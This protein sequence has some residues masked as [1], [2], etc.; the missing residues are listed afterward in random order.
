MLDGNELRALIRDVI[1]AEIAA[2]K[3]EAA[4]AKAM[5]AEHRVRI[6][7]DADLAA[8][9]KQVLSLANDP[10]T[11]SAIANGSYR[12]TLEGGSSAAPASSAPASASPRI[13]KGVVTETLLL[14][15]PKGTRRLQI[16]AGVSVTPLARDK[17]SSLGIT[18]ERMKP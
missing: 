16:G 5:P 11:R 2:V 10:A 9:A 13:D 17:A 7:N 15:L 6:A 4:P 3:R 12:F 14:K 18:I 1:A 8:F